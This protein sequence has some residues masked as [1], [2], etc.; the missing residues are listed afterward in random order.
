MLLL[1]R[2]VV[3]LNLNH[4]Y[5]PKYLGTKDL[6]IFSSFELLTE[7]QRKKRLKNNHISNNK[8]LC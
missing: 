3:F 5:F 7:V 4:V 8:S 2:G 6:S 1:G